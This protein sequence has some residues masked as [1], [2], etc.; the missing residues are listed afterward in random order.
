MAIRDVTDADL[1]ML[2][3]RAIELQDSDLWKAVRAVVV[4]DRER[5]LTELADRNIAGELLKFAQ[6]EL[7]QA[8]RDNMLVERFLRTLASEQQRR[9]RAS[10]RD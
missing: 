9:Q 4:A 1:S 3:V 10:E 6:D 5:I 2:R 8:N 7:A